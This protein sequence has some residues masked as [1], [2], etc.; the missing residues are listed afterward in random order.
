MFS[1]G[2]LG[3]IGCNAV[4]VKSSCQSDFYFMRCGHVRTHL[5][6]DHRRINVFIRVLNFRSCS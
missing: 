5:F 6:I 1:L 2:K 4:A 3:I